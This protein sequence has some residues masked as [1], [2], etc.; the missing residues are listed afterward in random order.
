LLVPTKSTFSHSAILDNFSYLGQPLKLKGVMKNIVIKL[1]AVFFITAAISGCET[2][3]HNIAGTSYGWSD[4]R[5]KVLSDIQVSNLQVRLVEFPDRRCVNNYRYHI[6]LNG[7]IGPDSTYVIEN[8]LDRIE[9]CVQKDSGRQLSILMYMNSGGGLLKDGYSLGRMLRD[10][11]IETYIAGNQVCASACAVAF[12]GGK[13]R[14]VAPSGQ[15][16]F[17]SPYTYSQSGKISCASKSD[18]TDLKKYYQEMLNELDGNRLYARTMD[19]CST[20]NGWTV[21]MDAAEIFNI[22]AK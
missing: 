7:E 4:S 10:Y 20:S 8:I 22:T 12:L 2:T 1:V 17:H 21:N 18:S 16:L 6:E 3:R 9:P 14:H 5:I 19:Y 13:F 11:E 15:L